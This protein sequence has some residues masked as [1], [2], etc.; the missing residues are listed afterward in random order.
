MSDINPGRRR[1]RISSSADSESPSIISE[2]LTKP[3]LRDDFTVEDDSL[4][5]ASE[6]KSDDFIL[7][8]KKISPSLVG[9]IDCIKAELNEESRARCDS[10]FSYHSFDWS[11]NSSDYDSFLGYYE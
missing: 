11:N 10:E 6:E 3:K 8:R 4:L 5:T 2:E 9:T 1:R 7:D